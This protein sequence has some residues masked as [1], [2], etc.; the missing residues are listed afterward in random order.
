MSSGQRS[1]TLRPILLGSIGMESRTD[2]IAIV[3]NAR[4]V[5]R[6][7][8]RRRGVPFSGFFFAPRMV[9]RGLKSFI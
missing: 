1:P 6:K 2:R 4:P 7:S 5:L 9:A 3:E 8:T